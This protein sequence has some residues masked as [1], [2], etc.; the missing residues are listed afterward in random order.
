MTLGMPRSRKK[1][2]VKH[3]GVDV[4]CSKSKSAMAPVRKRRKVEAK[5]KESARAA[6]VTEASDKFFDELAE[7]CAKLGVDMASP[8]LR[9]A[10]ARML[11]A[12]R[13]EW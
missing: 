7:T 10:S 6:G 1:G 3:G 11:K 12:T 13:G 4:G 8:G 5:A 2:G 9:E